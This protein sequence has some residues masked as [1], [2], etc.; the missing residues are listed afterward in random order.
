MFIIKKIANEN[1]SRPALQT[2]NHATPPKGYA[3]CPDKF[4]EVFY[5]T[6]P[7]GFVNITVENDVVTEMTVNQE[8]LDAYLE[9]LPEPEPVPE[10]EATTDELLDIILGVSANE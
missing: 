1:G 5:S 9:S 8:A 2:W 10:P 7:A 4:H 6:D 3:I